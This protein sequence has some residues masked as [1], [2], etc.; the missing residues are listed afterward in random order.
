MFK[1]YR[2]LLTSAGALAA[3][4]TVAVTGVTAASAMPVAPAAAAASGTLHVQLIS[5][6]ATSNTSKA[7]V[8]GLFT[9]GGVDHQGNK[10][11]RL[12]FK[13]GS[14]KVRHSPGKGPQT[15][16]PKTCLLTV[17][18]HGTYRIFGGTGKFKGVSGHGTYRVS[19]L[20]IA[21]RNSSGKCSM[22]KAPTAFQQVIRA[23]GPARI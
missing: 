3:A 8:F 18:Q 1:H 19:I 11:D 22:R 10:V 15:F 2:T 7:I 23:S 21:A 16:N 14:F 5:T 4:A 13:G 9:A 12:V 6:S 17:N 20:S